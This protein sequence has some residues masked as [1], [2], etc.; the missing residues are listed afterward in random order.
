MK[1][2]T[3]IGAR[4]QFIKHAVLS[5][6]LRKYH[7]EIVIHTGQHYD[8]NLSEMF[9]K[10]LDIQ[11]PNYNLNV[12]SG[13]HGQQTGEM[14]I[15]IEKVLKKENPDLVIVYG[16]TNSTLS[17]ALA[18]SKLNIKI[19]HVE[20]GLR[21]F[22]RSMPEEINRI[23]TDHISDYLFCPT[24]SAINNLFIEGITEGV[25]TV[26]DVMQ[27]SICN[28]FSKIKRKYDKKYVLA[29]IHRPTNTD[30][31]T[32]LT[33]IIESFNSLEYDVVFPVHPRTAKKLDEFGLMDKLNENVKLIRP[34]GYLEMLG[35]ESNAE[36]IITDSGGVQKEAYILGVPCVTVRNNTEWVET[37]NSGWNVLS[38]PGEI[39]SKIESFEVPENR[40]GFYGNKATE[41]IVRIL[42]M[43]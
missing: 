7:N 37:V 33:E 39:K 4:P 23:M 16:D 26:G 27:D 6:K 28:N 20:A 14:L 25:Y 34:V 18:A 8:Y 40:V 36:F 42:N 35:L 21:S 15:R 12:G 22:D 32:H 19:A 2:V 38:K 5:A 29:T 3:I 13:N 43:V 30:N 31:E 41:K 11:K 10:D 9:F 24:E 1:I 17:G